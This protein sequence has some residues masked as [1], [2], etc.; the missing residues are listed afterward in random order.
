L[1]DKHLHDFRGTFATELCLGGETD[2]SIAGIVGWSAK[3]VATIRRLYV[4]QAATV[5][6][7]GGRL[8][9]RGVKLTVNAKGEQR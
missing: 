2:E 1:A 9:N 3:E 8:A 5:V 7:M 4:D 6:A